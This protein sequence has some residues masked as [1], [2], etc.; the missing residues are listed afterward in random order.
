MRLYGEYLREQVRLCKAYNP[1]W[2]YKQMAEAIDITDHAFYNWLKGYY[3]L[4][5]KKQRKLK[6]LL[7]DLMS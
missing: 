5:Y 6:Y 7:D 2:S 3:N 1:D 4:S